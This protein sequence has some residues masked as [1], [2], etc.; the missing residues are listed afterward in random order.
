MSHLDRKAVGYKI[1]NVDLIVDDKSIEQN[2][3][4][5]KYLQKI[6]DAKSDKEVE[7][8]VWL[9]YDIPGYNVEYDFIKVKG[10]GS[11]KRADVAIKITRDRVKLALDA[12]NHGVVDTGKYQFSATGE[13]LNPFGF[14][15]KLSVSSGISDK[16]DTMFVVTGAYTKK[17]NSYGTGIGLIASYLE[18]NPDLGRKI[19]QNKDN[20]SKLFKAELMQPLVLNNKNALEVMLSVEKNDIKNFSQGAQSIEYDYLKG[21]IG[22]SGRHTDF[23]NAENNLSLNYYHTLDDADITLFSAGSNLGFDKEFGYFQMNYHRDQPFSVSKH[24]KFLSNLSML[25]HLQALRSSDQLPAENQF[26]VGGTSNGKGYRTGLIS[27]DKGFSF[28]TEFRYSHE[29][30]SKFLKT[31]QPYAFIEGAY[32]S[33]PEFT[34]SKKDFYSA[35]GGFRFRFMYDFAADVEVAHPFTKDVTVDGVKRENPTKVNFLV[36]K[37]FKF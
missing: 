17:L 13:L 36:F 20:S 24:D 35:G 37:E 22:L 29:L 19:S 32:I 7:R 16:S 5:Q 4:V 6:L 26:F 8:Y 31:I 2:S 33:K 23:L 14:N 25:L 18:D 9:L 27:A 12:N 11:N 15:D 21:M 1:N 10:H 34:V 28:Y 30:K 3:L